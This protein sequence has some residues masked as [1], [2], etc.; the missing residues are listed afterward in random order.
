MPGTHPIVRKIRKTKDL[1]CLRARYLSL[2]SWFISFITL[3]FVSSAESVGSFRF[4]ELARRVIERDF[5]S[6]LGAKGVGSPGL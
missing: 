3:Y 4:G 1:I 6:F 2:S 5:Y